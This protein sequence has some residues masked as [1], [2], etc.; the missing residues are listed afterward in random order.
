MVEAEMFLRWNKKMLALDVNKVRALPGSQWKEEVP[1]RPVFP[2]DCVEESETG[3]TT[4]DQNKDDDDDDDDS[5]SRSV[6]SSLS[7]E[8]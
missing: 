1:T 3:G 8:K 2:E 6:A 7:G 5:D 4:T